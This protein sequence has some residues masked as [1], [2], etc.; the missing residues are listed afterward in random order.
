MLL[1]FSPSKLHTFSSGK[2]NEKLK[3]ELSCYLVS[4]HFKLPKHQTNL[5]V[6]MNKPLLYSSNIL[7][8][9]EFLKIK[10]QLAASAIYWLVK[11]KSS[12]Y[13]A[14]RHKELN[15]SIIASLQ[16]LN[17][18]KILRR[19]IGIWRADIAVPAAPTLKSQ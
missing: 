16:Q 5:D 15:F 10:L 8:L 9:H 3:M 19:K 14:K 13:M 11:E 17:M 12:I 1:P 2:W 18:I 6:E 4:F 7:L